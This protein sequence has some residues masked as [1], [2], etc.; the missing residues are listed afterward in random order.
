[1]QRRELSW[2]GLRTNYVNRLAEITVPT[3]IL[4]GEN[5]RLL[6]LTI[7]ER[8]PRLIRSSRL[9]VIR[10]CGHLAPLEQPEAVNRALYDFLQPVL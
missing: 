9:D 1:L 6:P 10:H 3:L 4:H 8:A 7:A 5:N 2:R